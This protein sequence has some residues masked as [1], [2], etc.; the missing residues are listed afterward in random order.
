MLDEP[1]IGVGFILAGS[2]GG[3]NRTLNAEAGFL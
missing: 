2:G 1:G 3:V